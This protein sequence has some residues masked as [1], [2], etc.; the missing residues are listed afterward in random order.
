MGWSK[1]AFFMCLLTLDVMAI[2]VDPHASSYLVHADPVH[3]QEHDKGRA[4]SS[5]A[6]PLSRKLSRHIST[7]KDEYIYGRLRLETFKFSEM[8]HK[9]MTVE[10]QYKIMASTL[11]PILKTIT[12]TMPESIRKSP[13][14]QWDIALNQLDECNKEGVREMVRSMKVVHADANI[15]LK[16]F[17]DMYSKSIAY[18]KKCALQHENITIVIH[19]DILSDLYDGIPEL[20]NIYFPSNLDVNISSERF[21]Q[22]FSRS[23]SDPPI[24]VNYTDMICEM[25]QVDKSVLKQRLLL[26]SDGLYDIIHALETVSIAIETRHYGRC[27]AGY[28]E[29]CECLG[30]GFYTDK[31]PISEMC[32]CRSMFRFH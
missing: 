14:Y 10:E 26:L 1:F 3:E 25:L 8:I 24:F 13:L 15:T 31:S 22:S 32:P 28:Q 18:N 17:S 21:I 20:C 30:S 6:P 12:R 27:V 7:E 9:M 11:L 2:L 19:P 23:L 4:G 29:L 16:E 5:S